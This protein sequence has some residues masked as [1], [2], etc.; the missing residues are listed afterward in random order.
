MSDREIEIKAASRCKQQI[1]NIHKK[2]SNNLR[3]INDW[4]SSNLKEDSDVFV[5]FNG[6]KDCIACFLALK[7]LY[8]CNEKNLKMEDINVF[9]DFTKNH[10]KFK[11]PNKVK[12]LFFLNADCFDEEL[13]YCFN[14]SKNEELQILV[15]YTDFISGLF[16]TKQFHKL[17]SIFMGIRKDDITHNKEK[18]TEESD[19]LHK[20]DGKYPNFMRLYP[21][22]DF[23]YTE[24]WGLILLMNY[25][26]PEV[27][28]QGYSSLGKKS[29][30]VKNENLLNQATG[31]YLS[32][33]CLEAIDSE[34]T[35]RKFS[36]PTVENKTN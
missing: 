23:D 30:T 21:I 9:V 10:S 35:F 26:Y 29:K 2:L 6:G 24:I 11:L 27:Y 4:M 8:Y 7:Y 19:L 36:H 16:Y 34:R 25:P 33:Y 14:L 15:Q 32:A 1:E 18:S 28:D 3:V 13:D 31:N 17:Q 22:F 12:L 5:S 20:S